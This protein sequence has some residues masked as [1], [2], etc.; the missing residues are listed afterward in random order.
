MKRYV[1]KM[2]AV[3]CA[4]LSTGMILVGCSWVQESQNN[5]TAS[6]EPTSEVIAKTENLDL[7]LAKTMFENK[8]CVKAFQTFKKYAETG[9]AEAEA[10]LARCYMNG[11]GTS[12][13]FEKAYEY[14]RRAAEKDNPWGVNGL[15]V[16]RKSVV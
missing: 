8:D 14:F 7:Q 1:A 2:S 15:G 11:V 4:T 12:V 16:D 13:D 10:W 6:G 3:A 9:D 5:A